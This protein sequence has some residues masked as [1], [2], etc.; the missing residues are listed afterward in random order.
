MT[1]YLP[2]ENVQD[3][4]TFATGLQP[5]PDFIAM[6]E[7]MSLAPVHIV[8]A[9]ENG[10]KPSRVAVTSQMCSGHEITNVLPGHT[11]LNCV[12]LLVLFWCELKMVA[13]QD[14]CG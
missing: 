10:W 3:V 13:I 12:L 14:H 7:I 11:F 1:K 5:A 6:Y 8:D 2:L 9:T 4:E